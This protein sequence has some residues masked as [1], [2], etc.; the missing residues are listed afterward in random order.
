MC[1]AIQVQL[2]ACSRGILVHTYSCLM[3]K[4]QASVYVFEYVCM[5]IF[6]PFT[7]RTSEAYVGS[8]LIREH[9]NATV[10]AKRERWTELDIRWN[11]RERERE[12]ERECELSSHISKTRMRSPSWDVLAFFW[13]SGFRV[14][15]VS[16]VLS[17]STYRCLC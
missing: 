5:C 6:K 12:R 1:Q 13:G 10:L 16:S 2:Q 15:L 3:H 4:H 17:R 11:E 8:V 9:V 14:W 7:G